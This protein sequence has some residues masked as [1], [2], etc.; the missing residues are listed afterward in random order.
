MSDAERL[1]YER[2][3]EEL[4]VAKELWTK[5]AELVAQKLSVAQ[6]GDSL[7]AVDII[8]ENYNEALHGA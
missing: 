4:R 5:T 6:R 7:G 2:T 1:E 3:I 8:W